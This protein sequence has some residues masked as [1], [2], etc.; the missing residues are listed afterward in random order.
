MFRLASA[1]LLLG[2]QMADADCKGD[3]AW[4]VGFRLEV[5]ADFRTLTVHDVLSIQCISTVYSVWI[6]CMHRD[7]RVCTHSRI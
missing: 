2:F 5:C 7:F 6:Q 4:I 3:A 1:V